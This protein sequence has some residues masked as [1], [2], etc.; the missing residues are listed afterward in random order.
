M[1]ICDYPE[2]LPKPV[3]RDEGIRDLPRFI[4][5]LSVSNFIELSKIV[6]KDERCLGELKL[7]KHKKKNILVV[8]RT[9]GDYA[10]GWVFL[11]RKKNHRS[12]KFLNWCVYDNL[13]YHTAYNGF[14]RDLIE[15]EELYS[16]LEDWNGKL[17]DVEY[18]LMSNLCLNSLSDSVYR[19]YILLEDTE[20]D[21]NIIIQLRM[22]EMKTLMRKLN[23]YV[24]S[25]FL[26]E[27]CVNTIFSKEQENI[28]SLVEELKTGYLQG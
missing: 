16:M 13:V 8:L 6:C 10:K 25:G 2:K 28:T 9:R 21:G 7:F 17:T 19:R 12:E 20:I 5:E 15:C 22:W 1:S 4:Y 27:D 18:R 14:V 24:L 3:K 26:C 11:I 23:R